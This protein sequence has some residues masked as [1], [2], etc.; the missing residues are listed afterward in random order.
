VAA[1]ARERA[2]GGATG[3][4]ADGLPGRFTDGK[5]PRSAGD[6]AGPT[7]LPVWLRLTRAGTTITAETSV[8][9]SPWTPVG[10]AE[11]ALTGP[12]EVGL[13]V[14]AH[15][16]GELSNVTFDNVTVG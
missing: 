16:F 2:A 13:A 9:G 12:V 8:D 5:P 1:C 14:T 10:G 4:E 11:V 3:S 6:Q 7:A 15:D